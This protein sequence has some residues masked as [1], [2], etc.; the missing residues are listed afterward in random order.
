MASNHPWKRKTTVVNKTVG[1]MSPNL[2]CSIY[3]ALCTPNFTAYFVIALQCDPLITYISKKLGKSRLLS[4]IKFSV[5]QGAHPY[6][7][8]EP[9]FRQGG[10]IEV[11]KVEGVRKHAYG[12]SLAHWPVFPMFV[13]LLIK[14]SHICRVRRKKFFISLFVGLVSKNLPWPSSFLFSCPRCFC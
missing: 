11:W 10:T 13:S 1:T 3:L 4:G 12:A 8:Q 7:G 2:G 6:F 9:W 14:P 5:K